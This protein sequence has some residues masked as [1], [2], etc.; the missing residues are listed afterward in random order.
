MHVCVF[1]YLKEMCVCAATGL[2]TVTGV[3][4]ICVHEPVFSLCVYCIDALL[5][6]HETKRRL[7]FLG[8]TSLTGLSTSVRAGSC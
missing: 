2:W 1:I 5:F 6:A 7:L 8:G 4:N 3:V